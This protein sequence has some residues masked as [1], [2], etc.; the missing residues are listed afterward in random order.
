MD[1]LD[2]DHNYYELVGLRPPETLDN[3]RSLGSQ[4]VKGG[5]CLELRV[6]T[7]MIF[8][9]VEI[10]DGTHARMLRSHD[11]PFVTTRCTV[12]L[13]RAR[14]QTIVPPTTRACIYKCW[15]E[16]AGRAKCRLL[17]DDQEQLGPN[18]STWTR[19]NTKLKAMAGNSA[20]VFFV[21]TLTQQM[22]SLPFL[23]RVHSRSWT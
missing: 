16:D 3:S 10:F 12:A 8:I 9:E 23:D 17:L 21:K 19:E 13:V 11:L 15:T 22:Y 4:R 1:G 7:S 20:L 14:P 5:T 18:S 2:G 6:R